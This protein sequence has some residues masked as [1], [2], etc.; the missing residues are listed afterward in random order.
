MTVFKSL[1]DV[2]R[3]CDKFPYEID[4][5]STEDVHHATPIT[6]GPHTIGNVLPKV[7]AALN[8]YNERFTEKK[9]FVITKKYI[10]FADWV[11][12]PELRTETVR[13][14]MDTWREEKAFRVLA[15]WRNELYPVYGDDSQPDNI[16]F[17]MERAATALFG[18]STFGAHVNGYVQKHGE[19][20]M[21]V[22]KRSKTKPT[23]PGLWDNT[24]S[25][26]PF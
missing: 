26:T 2:V 10:T 20:H 3:S 6:L 11:N 12:T 13:A 9:P 25:I 24:V 18:V 21:W 17:A 5:N 4:I 14:L 1:L 19:I 16:A 8:E 23:Y 15:G 7:F 22:A